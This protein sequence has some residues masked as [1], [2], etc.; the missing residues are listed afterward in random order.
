MKKRR[1]KSIENDCETFNQLVVDPFMTQT[2]AGSTI[3]FSRFRNSGSRRFLRRLNETTSPAS[4]L[5]SAT[6]FS[7]I[8]AHRHSARLSVA[9]QELDCSLHQIVP[10]PFNV[11]LLPR[12]DQRVLLLMFR[13][14]GKSK[15][16]FDASAKCLSCLFFL[17]LHTRF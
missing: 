13:K 3:F 7:L 8:N 17:P 16:P 14:V 5:Y 6:L 12:Q 1:R 4:T 11:P 2:T 15:V 9:L 10:C